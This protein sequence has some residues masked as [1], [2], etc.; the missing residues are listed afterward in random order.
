M[1]YISWAFDSSCTMPYGASVLHVDVME[2]KG[3]V[4]NRS[5]YTS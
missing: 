2:K 3:N 5:T 1:K 4:T